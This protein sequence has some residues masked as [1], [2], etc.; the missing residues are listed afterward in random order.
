MITTFPSAILIAFAT[1]H[2][3]RGALYVTFPTS[4]SSCAVSQ[5]CQVK[6]MDNGTAPTTTTFGETTIDLVTGEA[7][8]LQVAQTLGG[9]SNPSVATA[10]TFQPSPSLSPTKQYAI[11]FKPK[12]NSANVVFSTFFTI[13][14]GSGGSSNQTAVSSNQTSSAPIALN[15]SRSAVSNNLASQNT[16]AST[17]SK[18][19]SSSFLQLPMLSFAT[20]AIITSFFLA[21]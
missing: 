5:P 1:A 3:A 21:R 16:T 14:G 2:F 15:S 10:L 6:W 12:G 9:V 11:R 17:N 19:S 20:A 18:S 8:N 13:T 7:S 4:G